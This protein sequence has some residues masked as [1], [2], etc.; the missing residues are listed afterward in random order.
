MQVI[1]VF[2]KAS[3][4]SR[5]FSLSSLDYPVNLLHWLTSHG[6]T[7]A[8]SCSGKGVCRKCLIQNDLATCELTV[9]SFLKL[10]PDGKI[11]VD[12]L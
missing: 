7:I 1:E 9:H 6:I 10:F 5:K 8:S 3:K 12:Y 2:G 4:T 11:Y